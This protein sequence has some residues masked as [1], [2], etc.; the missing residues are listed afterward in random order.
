MQT[1]FPLMPEIWKLSRSWTQRSR[2]ESVSSL[3]RT[4]KSWRSLVLFAV[5]HLEVLALNNLGRAFERVCEMAEIALYFLIFSMLEYLCLQ[6]RH[7][8]SFA[9]TALL[10]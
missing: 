7:L 4:W 10:Q 5:L 3:S 2:N 6:C 9:R 1:W 8:V